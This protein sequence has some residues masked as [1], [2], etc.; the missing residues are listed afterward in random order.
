MKRIILF[1]AVCLGLSVFQTGVSLGIETN[2]STAKRD[3]GDVISTNK[4]SS[5]ANTS[6]VR[7]KTETNRTDST[8]TTT[9]KARPQQITQT[10]N[11][12]GTVT[13]QA[14]RN[15]PVASDT[16]A[17]DNR[18]KITTVARPPIATRSTTGR[19]VAKK[20]STSRTAINTKSA[21]RISRASELDS[22]KIS[23][24]K[25][26]DYLKCK[27]VYYECMDEFC[28]NKDAN[29]RRCACS[30]R[31]HE[32]DAIKQQLS[33]AENKMLDF[34]QRLLTVGLDKEDALAINVA[35]EGEIGYETKDTS[36]SEKLLQKITNSLNSSGDSKMNNDLSAISLSLNV[37]TAWDSVDATSGVA[38]TSK[39]GVELYNAAI[40]ICEEM[41]REVCSDQELD[42]AQGSYKLSI[43]QDCNT[44][45]KAYD[46]QYNK[47]MEKIH[48]SSALLDMSRLNAYQQRNSD[49]ILT[50]K[51]KILDQLFDA[52]VCG[53]NLYKCLDVTGQYIDPATGN[54]FLSE[55]LYNITTL[56]TEP[57]GKE[58]WSKIPNNDKFVSFLNS[59]KLYL[60]PATEQCQEIADT[61]WK[62]FLDDALGQIKLA[63]NAKLEEIRQSCTTLVTECKTNALNSLSDF[64]ARA[65]STFEVISD[66]TANALCAKVENSCTSLLNASGGGGNTWSTGMT[67]IAAG[68]SY[69][70]IINNCT[71][72]G[73]DCIIQQCNGTAGNF[74]LCGD[75][76]TAPRRA[77]LRHDACWQDVLNCV[78]QSTNLAD[79]NMQ[80]RDTFYRD[81]YG[82][83]TAALADIPQPCNDILSGADKTACLITEQIWGNCDYEPATTAITTNSNLIGP[84]ANDQHTTSLRAQNKVL[85]PLLEENSSLLSWLS[86]NTGT[87][88][89]LDSCSA[90]KCPINYKYDNASNTCKRMIRDSE[91]TTTD[92]EQYVTIDQIITVKDSDD[93][94]IINYCDGGKSSKDMYGNCCASKTVSNGICVPADHRAIL[95]QNI[96]CDTSIDLAEPPVYY[97]PYVNQTGD[98]YNIAKTRN[99]SLYCVKSGSQQLSINSSGELVCTNGYL[100]IVDQYGNYITPQEIY[101]GP[102]MS[103][104]PNATTTCEYVFN[105]NK[106]IWESN[107][108]TECTHISNSTNTPHG[109]YVPVPTNNEFMITY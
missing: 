12:N 56:L 27:T 108:G 61:V 55:N 66:S 69:E 23:S 29:L 104:K 92:G 40:P 38:T 58:N 42:V 80:D 51:K 90:Y 68:I 95:I 30:A 41:A 99:M 8:R 89:A 49:D 53:T 91:T 57:T 54:A 20:A 13:R 102:T 78:K 11:R 47:A 32:F 97:C 10:S 31:T 39:S 103:Y 2:K 65:L 60:D 98:I 26:R 96:Y 83:T 74:A 7:Q 4:N 67:G 100:V 14:V 36:E 109:S 44:V 94:A 9:K 84:V 50:C 46:T 19:N 87:T 15:R 59:K 107:N 73:K 72:V 25:S 45:A 88:D 62:D 82:S 21:T 52:S 79:I 1:F 106:W 16:S 5:R 81:F 34:N 24:I 86:Y 75:Y 63:Q 28:A 35:S 76:S 33:D 37:D 105:G 93:N 48:E 101:T 77:I 71:T 18:T 6:T 17:H 43:Q 64:D 3:S 70:A 22:E 85:Q